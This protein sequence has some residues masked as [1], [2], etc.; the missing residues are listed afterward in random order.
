MTP[1]YRLAE[2]V[3][4]TQKVINE[5]LAIAIGHLMYVAKHGDPTGERAAK[6]LE[7][8]GEVNLDEHPD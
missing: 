5:R 7:I 6:A 2:H 1:S 4:E 3:V 8:I